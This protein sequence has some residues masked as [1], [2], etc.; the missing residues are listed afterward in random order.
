MTTQAFHSELGAQEWQ[1]TP[2]SST[3]SSQPGKPWSQ[4]NGMW[5]KW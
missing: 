1:D 4:T 2:I 3:Q 5:G